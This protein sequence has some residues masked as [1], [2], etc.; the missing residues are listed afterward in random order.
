MEGAEDVVLLGGEQT[1]KRHRPFVMA[2]VSASFEK[3]AALL[4]SWDYTL[5]S[6][7]AVQKNFEE[8]GESVNFFAIPNE[9]LEK[10]SHS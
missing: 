1:L 10:T 3:C 6:W 5:F 9:L 4:E 2:E 7:N 8:V